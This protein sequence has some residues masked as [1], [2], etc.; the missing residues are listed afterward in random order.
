MLDFDVGY[1]L[2]RDD[3]LPRTLME[4]DAV[5]FL[6]VQHPL[7]EVRRHQEAADGRLVALAV[8]VRRAQLPGTAARLRNTQVLQH[9]IALWIKVHIGSIIFFSLCLVLGRLIVHLGGV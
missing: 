9:G 2:E 3:I 7:I 5:H 4:Q 6:E 8:R 1:L